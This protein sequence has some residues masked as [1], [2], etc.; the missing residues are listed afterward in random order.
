MTYVAEAELSVPSNYIGLCNPELLK[1]FLS[2]E[3]NTQST[4]EEEMNFL[5]IRK[6]WRI[7]PN[8][9]LEQQCIKENVI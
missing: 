2:T 6:H 8:K 3:T 9:R 4:W 1:R 5:V 7:E